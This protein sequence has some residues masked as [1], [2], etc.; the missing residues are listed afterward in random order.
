MTQPNDPVTH[1][2]HYTKGDVECIE[3]IRASMDADAFFGYLKGQVLK[4]LWRYAHK[5]KPL[6]DLLKAQFYLDR[7]CEDYAVYQDTSMNAPRKA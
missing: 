3:A 7:L 1:P 2:S 5:G 4:Y 6:E